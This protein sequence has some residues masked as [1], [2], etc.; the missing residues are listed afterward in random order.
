M[1]GGKW[2]DIIKMSMLIDD[3]KAR[4]RSIA[5]SAGDGARGDDDTPDSE[6]P[7]EGGPMDETG[8]D[9]KDIALVMQQTNCS[10]VRAVRVLKESEGDLL[11]ASLL[12]SVSPMSSLTLITNNPALQSWLRSIKILC[13]SV[14]TFISNMESITF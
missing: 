10:R 8:V 12:I 9:P 3:W 2:K 13:P 11:K 5:S 6:A 14:F 4:G 1:Q 7:V